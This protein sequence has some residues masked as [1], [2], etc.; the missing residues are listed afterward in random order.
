LTRAGFA[1]GAVEDARRR[2]VDLGYLDDQGFAASRAARRLRQGRGARVVAAEL[3][4]KGVA[5]ELI[6]DVLAKIDQEDQLDRA[7]AIAEKLLPARGKERT[8]AA[9]LRRGYSR[10]LAR[11]ALEQAEL[12]KQVPE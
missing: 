1:A 5:S 11:T 2:L 12:V 7:R 8:L 10:W 3:R 9:L 4:Q 6:N